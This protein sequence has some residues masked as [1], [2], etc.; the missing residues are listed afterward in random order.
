DPLRET[1]QRA[2]M[3]VLAASGNYAAALHCYRDLRLHLHRELNT[4]P[5][6]ETQTLFQQLRGEA[7]R[8]SAKSSGL[9]RPPAGSSE[10]GGRSRSGYTPNLAAGSS[11]EAASDSPPPSE[12]V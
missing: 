3:Q 11:D 2:L 6:A 7:R 12:E 1:A 9:G 5:D 4:E 10:L 8:L